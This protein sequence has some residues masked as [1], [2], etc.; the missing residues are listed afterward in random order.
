MNELQETIYETAGFGLV[1]SVIE[2]FNGTMFAYGQT[3]S[4]KTFTMMGDPQSEKV[5]GIIPRTFEHIVN[6]I[7]SAEKN[8]Q[9]L[10]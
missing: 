4:G 3:G 10:V 5:K 9:F 7:E 2:G 6:A 8:K 1:E